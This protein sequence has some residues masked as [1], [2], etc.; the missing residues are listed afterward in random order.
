MSAVRTAAGLGEITAIHVR[1]TGNVLRTIARGKVRD[2]ASVLRNF[3]GAFS[4]IAGPETAQRFGNS[5]GAIDVTV[6]VFSAEPSGGVA[7]YTYA[8]AQ[9][10]AGINTWAIT[11]A[12]SQQTGF[13]CQGLGQ[14]DSDEAGFTCTVTDSTG[15]TAVT[16]EVTARATN[17]GGGL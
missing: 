17:L 5:S 8:W 1:D 13:T 9:T 14:F 10:T 15:A 6:S 3:F 11:A 4:A 12:A 2:E 16:N 7:P